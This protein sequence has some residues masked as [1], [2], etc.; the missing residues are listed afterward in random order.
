[1]FVWRPQRPCSSLESSSS[2][3]VAEE[4]IEMAGCFG[5]RGCTRVME[6]G[7]ADPTPENAGP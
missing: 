6:V 3:I 4:G 5:L 1:M 7:Y 2:I